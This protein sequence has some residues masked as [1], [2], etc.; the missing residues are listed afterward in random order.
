MVWQNGST[1]IV[2]Q[3]AG[4]YSVVNF[5]SQNATEAK[6]VM[7]PEYDFNSLCH[8]KSA[9]DYL[10]GTSEGLFYSDFDGTKLADPICLLEDL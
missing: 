8:W 7:S 2:G 3:E 5:E 10:I 1:L 9:S 6:F 4:K